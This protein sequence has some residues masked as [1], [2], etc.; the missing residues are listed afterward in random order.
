MGQK[1]RASDR[2]IRAD[3]KERGREAEVLY[4]YNDEQMEISYCDTGRS[5]DVKAKHYILASKWTNPSYKPKESTIKW[6]KVVITEEVFELNGKKYLAPM[7]WLSSRLINLLIGKGF[8]KRVGRLASLFS[9]ITEWEKW[10]N[11]EIKKKTIGHPVHY[12]CIVYQVL[13]DVNQFNG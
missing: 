2:V 8:L 12:N 5:Y 7:S 1:F 10:E 13:K 9:N 3:G 6:T 11:S 4:V